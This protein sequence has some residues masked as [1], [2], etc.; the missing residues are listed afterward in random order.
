M[1]NFRSKQALYESIMQDVSKIVK[2][3]LNEMK[4]ETYDS[5]ADKRQAQLDRL[6]PVMKRQLTQD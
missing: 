1:R 2:R 5:A 3:H 4:P 6:S